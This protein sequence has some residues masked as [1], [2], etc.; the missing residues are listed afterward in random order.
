MAKPDYLASPVMR[1]ATGFHDNH[2]WSLFGH[3]LVKTLPRQIFAELWLTRHRCT[4][5]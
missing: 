4:V 2:R 1:A 3:E 5:T